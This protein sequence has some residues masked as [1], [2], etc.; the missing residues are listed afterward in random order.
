M[1]FPFVPG[2]L[3]VLAIA[4]CNSDFVGRPGLATVENTSLPAPDPVSGSVGTRASV[5]GPGDKVSVNVFGAADLSRSVMVESDGSIALPLIG[6]LQA[7][8]LTTGELGGAIRSRLVGRYI[9]DPDVS[10]NIEEVV[11]QNFAIEGEVE[12]PGVYPLIGSSTLMRAIAQGGGTGEYARDSLVMIFRRVGDQDMAALY[13]IDAIRLGAYPDP[14]IY[15]GD[16]VVV[17]ENRAAR[18]F[19]T[20]IQGSGILVAPLVAVLN[21]NN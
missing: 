16:L 18:V 11:S 8:G 10:V 2:I 13:D 15:P 5:L 19:G 7:A 4:G 9:R 21:N 14:E 6:T 1:K 3:A 17:S 20:L 12:E